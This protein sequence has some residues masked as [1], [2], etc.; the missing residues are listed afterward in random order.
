MLLDV[1]NRKTGRHGAISNLRGTLPTGR[2]RK[3]SGAGR[4]ESAEENEEVQSAQRV[5]EAQ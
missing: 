4:G 1:S 3:G 2:P 5:L